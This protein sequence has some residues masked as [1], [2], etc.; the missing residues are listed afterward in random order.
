M[1]IYSVLFCFLDNSYFLRGN[2]YQNSEWNISVSTPC[3]TVPLIFNLL[4][5]DR[6]AVVDEPLCSFQPLPIHIYLCPSPT[7][8]DLLQSL[9]GGEGN[10]MEIGEKQVDE[11]IYS[12]RMTLLEHKP[13]LDGGGK[14]SD[15][16]FGKFFRRRLNSVLFALETTL[17]RRVLVELVYELLEVGI[18]PD[19]FRLT[20]HL[21]LN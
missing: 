10:E 21:T 12:L 13:R 16:A 6:V 7:Y 8:D 15:A 4:D 14:R 11:W 2:N 1:L 17:R 18:H 3:V 20:E 19:S 5:N 9:H